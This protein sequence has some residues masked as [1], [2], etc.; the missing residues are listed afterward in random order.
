VITPGILRLSVE[1]H[2]AGVAALYLERNPGAL[3]Q[4]VRDA[5]YAKTTKG[6]V[7]RSKTTNSHLLFTDY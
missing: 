1:A 7:K 4:A 3:P 5:L 6:V 2:A